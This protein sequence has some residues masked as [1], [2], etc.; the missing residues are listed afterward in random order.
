MGRVGILQTQTHK[1]PWEV[2]NEDGSATVDHCVV[3]ERWKAAF[4][5]L[6]NNEPAT[7]TT[8]KR[9]SGKYPVI[10]DTT[11]FNAV[12]T[13]YKVIFALISARK[14][15]SLGED[16]IPVEVLL[17]NSCLSYLI[18]LFNACFEAGHI[19]VIWSR[20]II[21]PILKDSTKDHRD[22]L[23]YRGI[24]VTSATY[25]LFCSILNYRLTRAI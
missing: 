16:G 18:N 15:K 1:I 3:L 6:L 11:L 23:N 14:G 10:N 5:Q 12:I 21:S 7:D 4:E 19:P 25:K 24:T 9:M 17:N 13:E 22:P 20:G 8:T 2:L